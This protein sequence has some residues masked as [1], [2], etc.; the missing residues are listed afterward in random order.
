MYTVQWGKYTAAAISMSCIS[1]LCTDECPK[2]CYYRMF[3]NRLI[4]FLHSGSWKCWRLEGIR[5]FQIGIQSASTYDAGPSVSDPETFQKITPVM[6]V[7]N[8][9]RW[10]SITFTRCRQ[11]SA[12]YQRFN[13]YINTCDTLRLRWINCSILI[14]FLSNEEEWS[15]RFK[16]FIFNHPSI[17]DT[18]T[19][20][21][22]LSLTFE[23]IE[24]RSAVISLR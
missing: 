13:H 20:I 1:W 17:Y 5:C 8:Q 2:F 16:S 24:K 15:H 10:L 21:I 7:N 23:Y 12:F 4:S 14:W 9:G 11:H 22:F 19:H 18:F 3:G 6:V